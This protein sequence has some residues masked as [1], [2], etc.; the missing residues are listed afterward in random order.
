MAS[1][2]TA[3]EARAL[4]AEQA[5][6]QAQL[7]RD[8]ADQNREALPTTD[9]G[10]LLLDIESGA[11]LQNLAHPQ[12]CGPSRRQHIPNPPLDQEDVA[13][14]E[15]TQDQSAAQDDIAQAEDLAETADQDAD[16]AENAEDTDMGGVT[17][18]PKKEPDS[19]DVA[20]GAVDAAQTKS[21]LETAARS[22]LIAQTHA[23]IQPSYSTWFDM[24]TIHSI[25]KKALPEWFNS[26]NRSKTP[27]TYKDTRDFMVNTYRLNPSEYLTFTACRRNLC[28]DVCAILR[29]HQFLEQWGL[30]N[31]QV[32]PDTRPS[33]IGPPFTGHFRLTA[34]TPRGL[35]PHQPAP[36]TTT[37]GKPHPVT[38]RLASAQ[39]PTKSELNLEVRR[40]IYDQ[41]GKE[42][43]PA[44]EGTEGEAATNGTA[45]NAKDLLESLR[46]PTKK[47]YCHSCANDCTR[48]RYH[49]SKSAPHSATG[50]AA[51]ATKYDLCP[52]CFTDKHFPENCNASD[53]T[54]IEN[55]KY[56]IIPD[57]DAEWSDAE[58]LALLEGLEMFNDDW[59]EISD[60]VGTRSR[61][62]CVLK[63]LQLEIEDQYLEPLPENGPT[64]DPVVNATSTAYMG[65]G[66]IPF[67]QADNP[68]LSVMAYLTGLA[69]PS[70]TAAAAGKTVDEVKRT[71]LARIEKLGSTSE[72]G[73]EKEGEQSG[74]APTESSD[75]KAEEIMDVDRP[76]GHAAASDRAPSS[77]EK[78]QDPLITI[79]FA[80]AA[81][82]AAALA[83]HEER[84]LTRLCNAAVNLQLQKLKLKMEQ[85]GEL[86]GLL[87]AERRDLERR[88][89]ALF[90]D[91]LA[92]TRRVN[93]VEEAMK[94][95]LT[96]GSIQDGLQY[97]HDTM[98]RTR[99]AE[100]ITVKKVSAHESGEVQPLDPSS[101]GY[102]SIEI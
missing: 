93:E 12:F 69:D 46:E 55:D 91:R 64:S 83:S 94:H 100:G 25:E 52:S 4:A 23:I 28:G 18:E 6:E 49:C 3:E 38:E 9:P 101:A 97:I 60:Y 70:V 2:S 92:F 86:E 96:M 16:E 81:G 36:S 67:S 40:N 26:R 54:K 35:Q 21:S 95:A 73:K 32:D 72:K 48:L 99:E 39:P 90:L 65:S 84:T 47:Y 51:A 24:N 53:F 58:T 5:R 50:S 80:L 76:E 29:V 102:R 98:K 74:A 10:K 57:R 77:T 78:K 30:I 44:K 82:R 88:R 43:T 20:D 27:Q 63:F 19:V 17:E 22:H 37:A 31:Y 13:M 89:Q 62:E 1:G 68:V 45:E 41:N 8:L 14:A 66:R 61:E 15:D 42:A 34:D 71:M 87:Q 59:N 85:F 79:P 11:Y 33:S 75:V 56:S 7:S